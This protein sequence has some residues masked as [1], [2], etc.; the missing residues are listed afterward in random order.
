MLFDSQP[1]RSQRVAN[2]LPFLGLHEKET[3]GKGK[4]LRWLIEAVTNEFSGGV[5]IN[6]LGKGFMAEIIA[7]EV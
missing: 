1:Q 6:P 7:A 2:Q 5:I 3:I 4:K